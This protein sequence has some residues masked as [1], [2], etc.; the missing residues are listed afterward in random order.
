MND[1]KIPTAIGATIARQ[2][3]AFYERYPYP[4]PVD[5]LEAYRQ[6]LGLSAPTRRLPSLLAG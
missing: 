2:V 6:A 5:D 1:D 3:T 4:P